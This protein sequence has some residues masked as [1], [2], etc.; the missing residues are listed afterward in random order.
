M[1]FDQTDRRLGSLRLSN[2]PVFPLITPRRSQNARDDGPW[3]AMLVCYEIR[4]RYTSS[5]GVSQRLSQKREIR[6]EDHTAL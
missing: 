5:P 3:S 4:L 1:I 6:K 2:L